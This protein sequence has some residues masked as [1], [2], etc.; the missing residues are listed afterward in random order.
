M[1]SFFPD[2]QICQTLTLGMAELKQEHWLRIAGQCL[3]GDKCI[4]WHDEKKRPKPT[5]KTEPPSEPPTQRG[6]CASRKKNL[7]G[8][9]PS[10]KFARQPC[11][12]YLKGICT[13]SLCDYWHPP[14]CRF[15]KSESG[16]TF[17]DKCSF[18]HRQ[19]EGQPSKIFFFYKR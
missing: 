5:P 12:D 9:S 2:S 19:V 7:R 16:C 6:R 18:A 15:Y 4:F 17:G 10:G 13:K 3:R 8:R 1:N 14:E 11:K